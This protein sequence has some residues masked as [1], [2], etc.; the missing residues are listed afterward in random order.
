[1]TDFTGLVALLQVYDMPTAVAFYHDV[2][3][4]ELLEHSPEIE[5]AEGRYFH[6][7]RLGRDGIELML[8][9]AHDADERPPERDRARDA[10][11]GDICLYIGCPDLDAAFAALT[12]AGLHLAGPST[13][14]YGMRQL[15]LRDP[16]GYAICLQ[17]PAD[18][19]RT[20]G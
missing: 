9:T 1:M 18:A 3:G 16:D 14:P 6:W 10:A 7:C 12:A 5:A 20:T 13:A 8:N 15:S 11:H 2:L 19:A 4:F 17:W